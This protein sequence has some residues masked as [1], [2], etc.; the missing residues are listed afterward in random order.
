[1]HKIYKYELPC[2]EKHVIQLPVGAKIIRV[3]D[4]DGKFF[5]WAI[6]DT[7]VLSMKDR[8]LEFYKTG[9]PIETD[10]EDLVFLGTCKLFVG[11]ELC[12]YVFER[13]VTNKTAEHIKMPV[14]EEELLKN[15][16]K[17]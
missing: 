14:L 8:Y 16:Q 9:Q 17:K 12:L 1:M 11:M 10:P 2:K 4:V 6:V 3:E 7:N 13:I 5:L 15:E